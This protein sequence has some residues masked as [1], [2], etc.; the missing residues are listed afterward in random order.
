MSSGAEL[1]AGT[2]VSI[3][4]TPAEDATPTATLNGSSVILTE[5]DGTYTGSFTM[6][7]GDATLAINT[8]GESEGSDMN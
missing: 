8:G 1:T 2:E 5:N 6:P 7:S 3:S 4:I